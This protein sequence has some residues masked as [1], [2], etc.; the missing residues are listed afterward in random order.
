MY[1]QAT[2]VETSLPLSSLA[3]AL[4]AFDLAITLSCLAYS[5]IPSS[6]I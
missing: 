6:A 3:A 4:A 1:V 2:I 5:A